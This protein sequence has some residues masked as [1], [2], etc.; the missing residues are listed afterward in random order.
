MIIITTT[1]INFWLNSCCSTGWTSSRSGEFE[2]LFLGDRS[3][4]ERRVRTIE[5]TGRRGRMFNAGSE[6][7]LLE[8][9]GGGTS[10]RMSRMRRS[11]F[12][13]ARRTRFRKEEEQEEI[14]EVCICWEGSFLKLNRFLFRC[15]LLVLWQTILSRLAN[16][17]NHS[18]R[19]LC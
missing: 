12:V 11:C 9:W 2:G 17:V 8:S 5:A 13:K 6:A 10:R 1:N 16:S 7:S 14:Q 3:I 19:V 4:G 18:A 15:F